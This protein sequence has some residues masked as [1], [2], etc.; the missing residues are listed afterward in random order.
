MRVESLHR[1][2]IVNSDSKCFLLASL[3]PR[4]LRKI[5]ITLYC[6]F[7]IIYELIF[8]PVNHQQNLVTQSH[9]RIFFF[10]SEH[11]RWAVAATTSSQIL[12]TLR[13]SKQYYCLYTRTYMDPHSGFAVPNQFFWAYNGFGSSGS[14]VLEKNIPTK[15]GIMNVKNVN[16]GESF[17]VNVNYFGAIVSYCI[18]VVYWLF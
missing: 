4:S 9:Y 1:I 12:P 13:V 6:R 2:R 7:D 11:N 16:N 14:R 8:R 5:W 3:H 10:W 18:S 15:N 17:K